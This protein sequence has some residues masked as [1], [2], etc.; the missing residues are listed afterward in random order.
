MVGLGQA[1][2]EKQPRSGMN[3]KRRTATTRSARSLRAHPTLRETAARLL[4]AAPLEPSRVWRHRPPAPPL[5]PGLAPPRRAWPRPAPPA[6]LPNKAQ[7]S[8]GNPQFE[9]SNASSSRPGQVYAYSPLTSFALAA[10]A[11]FRTAAFAYLTPTPEITY[12][13]SGSKSEAN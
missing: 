12:R 9:K 6:M 7:L 4:H 13:S 5:P 10:Q 2:T 3:R 1:S 8:R 11:Q